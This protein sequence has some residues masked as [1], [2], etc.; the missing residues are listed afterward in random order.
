MR[1]TACKRRNL[2]AEADRKMY[3]MKQ[4]SKA[5]QIARSIGVEGD[6]VSS[7]VQP[8]EKRMLVN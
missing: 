2:L 6:K 1:P 7:N 3:I 5:H 4:R 8:P